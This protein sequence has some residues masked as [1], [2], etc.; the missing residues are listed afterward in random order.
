MLAMCYSAVRGYESVRAQGGSSRA[1]VCESRTEE[2]PVPAAEA[3]ASL[4]RCVVSSERKDMGAAA[5]RSS[6]A[7]L[8]HIDAR[9]QQNQSWNV[10]YSAVI[11]IL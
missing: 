6:F 1:H 7:A 4:A 5:R 3:V 11:L 9:F 8:D 2:L 10:V